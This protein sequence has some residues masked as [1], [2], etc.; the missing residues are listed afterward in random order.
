MDERIEQ[1]VNRIKEPLLKAYGEGIKQVIL[2]GSCAR[3]KA[4]KDSDIDLLVVVDDS[5]N[6]F[7]VRKSLSDTIFDVLLEKG[8]LFSVIVVPE[9]FFKNYN[10]PFLLNV[11]EEGILT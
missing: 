9:H 4:T 8:E 11:K 10:S 6:P 1:L 2:Y 7:E 5:L 3:G